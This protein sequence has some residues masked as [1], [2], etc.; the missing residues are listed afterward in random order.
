MSFRV[1]LTNT[2]ANTRQLRQKRNSAEEIRKLDMDCRSAR[3][4]R[5]KCQL[6]FILDSGESALVEIRS[7]LWKDTLLQGGYDETEITSSGHVQVTS[8]PYHITPQA[9]HG[10]DVEVTT[11]A[12]T[13][14]PQPGILP[15]SIWVLVVSI[16]SGF[17]LLI[18]VVI[19]LWKAGFFK[20][21]RVED[22]YTAQNCVNDHMSTYS[23][24]PAFASLSTAESDI[25]SSRSNSNY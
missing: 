13:E 2:I 7:R 15:I 1:N 5:I 4:V 9:Y 3:C 6:D 20:R 8:M 25:K 17:L 12:N 21:K 10:A 24:S 16:V 18:L 23:G 22:E 14:R 11:I 19:G